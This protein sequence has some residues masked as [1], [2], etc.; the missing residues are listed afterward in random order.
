[1]Y[2]GGPLHLNPHPADPRAPGASFDVTQF[3]TAS[4]LQPSSNIVTFD[5]YFNNLRRDPTKNADLSMSKRFIFAE[6]RYLEMRFE[7]FNIT[8]RVTFAA[9]STSA[10]STAFATITSQANTP[11]RIQL[12]ARLVF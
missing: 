2:L 1:V 7:G 5:S 9:P 10:T 4:G 8:N 3:Y 12:G 11:R 6:R